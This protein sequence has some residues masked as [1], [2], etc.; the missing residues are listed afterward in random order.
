MV[1]VVDIVD[2][3]G[4]DYDGCSSGD[5]LNN[6]TMAWACGCWHFGLLESIAVVLQVEVEAVPAWGLAMTRA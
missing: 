1:V 3:V 2:V 4:I 5:D 6:T